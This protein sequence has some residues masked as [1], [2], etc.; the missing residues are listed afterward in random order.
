MGER[1]PQVIFNHGK[2]SGPN[3][4]KIRVL[5]GIAEKHGF[6]VESVDYTDIMDQEQRVHRLCERVAAFEGT[7]QLLVGSSMGA[8]VALVAAEVIKPQ[9]LFLMAP[10]VY[11]PGWQHQEYA[12]AVPCVSV[13]H[14]WADEVIPVDHAI[15]YAQQSRCD[16]HLLDSDHRL[17][18]SLDVVADIFESFLRK[19]LMG[20]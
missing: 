6:T 11:I 15:R 10:A 18:N 14:G 4:T 16:L 13:V 3:G 8:Y 9:A 5:S 20:G 17:G 7:P 19:A 1:C 2:E 12:A